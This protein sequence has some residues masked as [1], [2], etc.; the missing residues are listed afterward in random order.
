MANDEWFGSEQ[1][2]VDAIYADLRA[3]GKIDESKPDAFKTVSFLLNGLKA[4][5]PSL[6]PH[7]L[8]WLETKTYDRDLVVEGYTIDRL[9][10]E[11]DEIVL[12]AL[13]WLSA[14]I[15]KPEKTLQQLR[16]LRFPG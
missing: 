9:L 12:G 1:R 5:H 14:L 16:E 3:T 11:K 15:E 4:L 6:R 8:R 13:T 2:L 7:L 10:T